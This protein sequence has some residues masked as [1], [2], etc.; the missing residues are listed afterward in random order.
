MADAVRRGIMSPADDD[1]A[2]DMYELA[3]EILH[4]A[5]WAHYEIAN[6]S[7]RLESA[8]RHNAI[9]WRN[10]DYAGLGAG[11]HGHV[12][13]RRTMNQPSPR[14]YVDSISAHRS[15]VT[16]TEAIDARTEM[17]ETMMLGLR[18]LQDGVSGDAFLERHG[19]ALD[20]QFGTTMAKLTSL[21]LV[22]PHF[23]G[24]RLTPRGALLANMVAAEF[25]A[26]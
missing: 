1:L 14:R 17:T 19:I 4:D 7:A 3:R 21:G 20:D 11:A 6:W 8:S 25:L 23:G 15:P 22:E 9:Y 18:L 12:G 10:G 13:D 2:A 24:I 5:G 26:D 16:N